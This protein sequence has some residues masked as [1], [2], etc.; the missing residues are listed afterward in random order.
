[1]LKLKYINNIRIF[2]YYFYCV[3]MNKT[4][5]IFFVDFYFQDKKLTVLFKKNILIKITNKINFVSKTLTK[6]LSIFH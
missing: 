4:A 5:L 2:I 3:L 1:M 6:C